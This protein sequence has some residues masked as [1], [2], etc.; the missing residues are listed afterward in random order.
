M[1]KLKYIF[2]C[3]QLTRITYEFEVVGFFLFFLLSFV[4][5]VLFCCHL[6]GLIAVFTC[7]L[8]VDSCFLLDISMFT[9]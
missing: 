7:L 9:C 6:T 3:R 8:Q 5:I 1:L 2:K 4:G